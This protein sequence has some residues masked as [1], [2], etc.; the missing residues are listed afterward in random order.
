MT[1]D[2]KTSKVRTSEAFEARLRAAQAALSAGF[3][4]S[5]AGLI[6]VCMGLRTI[7]RTDPQRAQAL[8]RLPGAQLYVGV[9]KLPRGLKA[10]GAAMRDAGLSQGWRDELLDL[11]LLRGIDA[12]PGEVIGR[13]E[14]A[15]F[16]P[17]GAAT[18]AVHLVGYL[19][20]PESEDDPVFI[21]GQ[22]SGR[23]LIGPG[24]W[25]GLAAGMIRAGETPAE[26]LAREAAEEAGLD[27]LATERLRFLGREWISR[28][29]RGGWMHEMSHAYALR[30]PEGW[31]PR[32][33]DG[34][35]EQFK[36]MSAREVLGLI[37]DE[38]MM[39][40]A[41]QAMLLAFGRLFAL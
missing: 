21:L 10:F 22:R 36:A 11:R 31:R 9:L 29:V 27:Q 26:G 14:R 7:G 1:P 19:R 39:K 15:L 8:A 5:D 20:T 32:P 41:A 3:F 38:Q 18:A 23:K 2:A 25:D 12:Q 24:L 35:V 4:V 13:M 17:L 30:L 28:P 34:E 33:V 16:R 40:E 37:E 6:P